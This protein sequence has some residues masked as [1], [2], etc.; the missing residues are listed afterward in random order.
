MMRRRVFTVSVV[1]AWLRQGWSFALPGERGYVY[2]R[3]PEGCLEARR[4]GRGVLTYILRPAS[5]QA[6]KLA[7]EARERAERVVWK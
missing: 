1:K 3:V 6:V 5:E 4:L 7:R 2:P